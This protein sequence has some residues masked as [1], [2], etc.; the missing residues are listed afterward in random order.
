MSE[1]GAKFTPANASY[2]NMDK[3]EQQSLLVCTSSP[4]NFGLLEI[5]K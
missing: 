3:V 2:H 4:K 5:H 1:L